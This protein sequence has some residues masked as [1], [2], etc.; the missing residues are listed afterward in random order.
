MHFLNHKMKLFQLRIPLSPLDII[1]LLPT[2]FSLIWFMLFFS[3]LCVLRYFC[4][5]VLV[6]YTDVLYYVLLDSVYGLV[7]V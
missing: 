1:F 2:I 4:V 5:S 7:Q 6:V 3:F